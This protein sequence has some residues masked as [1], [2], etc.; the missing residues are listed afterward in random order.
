MI[1]G[2][3]YN[4]KLSVLLFLPGFDFILSPGT[5]DAHLS[6]C[7]LPIAAMLLRSSLTYQLL[8]S[9]HQRFCGL[10]LATRRGQLALICGYIH[11][12]DGSRLPKLSFPLTLARQHTALIIL[13]I[14]CNGHRESWGPSDTIKNSA[15]ALVEDFILQER[16]AVENQ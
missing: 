9:I 4:G 7:N 16:L 15:G 14:D 11:Y 13:G 1:F 5:I 3:G 12:K 2:D 6:Q 8:P 10:L